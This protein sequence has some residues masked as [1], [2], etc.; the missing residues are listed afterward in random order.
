MN[1]NFDFDSMFK[2]L[3]LIRHD[4]KLMAISRNAGKCVVMAQMND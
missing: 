4:V 2:C 1:I 3:S